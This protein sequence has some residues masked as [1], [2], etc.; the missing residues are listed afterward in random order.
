VLHQPLDGGRSEGAQLAAGWGGDKQE[1]AFNEHRPKGSALDY[2]GSRARSLG[3]YDCDDRTGLA[4][5][6]GLLCYQLPGTYVLFLKAFVQGYNIA[7][8]HDTEPHANK[9]KRFSLWSLRTMGY[10]SKSF[11]HLGLLHR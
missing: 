6:R 2:C 4:F 7:C 10:L 1:M 8:F 9:R 3:F 11:A 5:I